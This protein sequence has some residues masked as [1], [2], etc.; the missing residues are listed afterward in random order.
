VPWWHQAV[1]EALDVVEWH[2]LFFLTLA[3]SLGL[4][5]W[6]GSRASRSLVASSW[7][8]ALWLSGGL[9][10]TAAFLFFPGRSPEGLV[11][12]GLIVA[13]LGALAAALLLTLWNEACA[14]R[15]GV[16]ARWWAQVPVSGGHLMATSAAGV[17]LG[18]R[19]ESALVHAIALVIGVGVFL[20]ELVIALPLAV[21]A[22]R[23]GAGH[24]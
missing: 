22:S 8:S 12:L 1:L 6:L 14:A 17:S 3:A 15:G 19:G 21:I 7:R 4:W 24:E 11:L 9:A 23:H 10:A 16:V 20:V 13:I 2:G 18:Y 5:L